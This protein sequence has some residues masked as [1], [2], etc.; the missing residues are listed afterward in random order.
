MTTTG[1][2]MAT[3]RKS[4]SLPKPTS[5]QPAACSKSSPTSRAFSSTLAISSTARSPVPPAKSYKQRYAFCLETQHFP[6]SPNHP[7]FPTT[8]LKPGETFKSTTIFPLLGEV[9]ILKI[10]AAWP[11]NCRIW[12][13]RGPRRLFTKAVL[14]PHLPIINL[15]LDAVRGY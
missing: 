10:S 15:A 2:S 5:R 13:F 3:A 7:K 6:D 8:E 9:G 12:Q 4:W 14:P 11:R 1:C